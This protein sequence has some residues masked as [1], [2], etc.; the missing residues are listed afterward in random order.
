M[1]SK[2]SILVGTIGQGV[3]RSDDDGES[4]V[5]SS[6]NQ[7]MHSDCITKVLAS[8]QRR[9]RVVFAGTD[10]GLYRSDDAGEHWQLEQTPM[11]GQMVWALAID[12]VDPDVVFA[13]TGTPNTPGVFRSG[14]GGKAWERCDVDIAETCPNVG[15]PR[16]TGIA[17]DPS[18]H[19]SV[20][21]GLEVDGLRHSADGGQTWRRAA[22]DIP[23]AD[24]HNVLVAGDSPKTV[25]T[26]VNNDVWT[27][28]DNGD[29]W[30]PVGARDAFPW[31]Y[32]RGIASRPDDPNVVFVTIGDATP[33]RIGTVMRSSDAGNTWESL[34]LPHQPNSAMWTVSVSPAAPDLVLAASRYGYLYRSDDGGDSWTKLWREFGEVSSLLW[35]PSDA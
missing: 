19:M 15:I 32:P 7:G 1:T 14:D 26:V 5:R 9:P 30:R 8:D 16:V 27:S 24:V 13:G 3:M 2:G 31:S 29:S 18:D 25:F 33:G 28:V 34:P 10:L 21:A 6:V 35:L 12:P 4:W 22:P 20:W 17:I 11:D 23:N